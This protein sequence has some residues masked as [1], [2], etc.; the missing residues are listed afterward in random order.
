MCATIAFGMGVDCADVRQVI[1]LGVPEDVEMYIQQTG[2]A[3][4]NGEPALALLLKVK[5]SQRHV[6]SCMQA[7]Q[8][9]VEICR[10]K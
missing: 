3:G 1:T 10:R 6:T 4:R 2:R 7:Y 5:G 9:N 8:N